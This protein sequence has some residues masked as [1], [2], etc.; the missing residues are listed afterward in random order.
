MQ[1]LEI[2]LYGRNGQKRALSFRPGKVNVITG[3]STTGKSQIIHVIDYCCGSKECRVAPGPLRDKVAWYGLLLATDRGNVFVARQTPPP[4]GKSTVDAYLEEAREGLGSPET[5]E[6]ANTSVVAS[7]RYLRDVVGI[8]EYEFVPTESH[9]T[10]PPLAPTFRHALAFCLQKQTEIANDEHLFHGQGDTYTA[11]AYRDLFPY[12]LG[13]VDTERLSKEQALRQLRAQLRRV[14]TEI[15]EQDDIAGEGLGQ[16]LRL[17]EEARVLGIVTV[18]GNPADVN[19]L[20]EQLREASETWEPGA[21]PL[22]RGDRLSELRT[23]AD[24]ISE[25][26]ERLGYQADAVRS[27]ILNH[28]GRMSANHEQQLR[29]ESIGL[30]EPL[31]TARCSI[32]E[33]G[34]AETG[35]VVGGMWQALSELSET[36]EKAATTRP[37]FSDYLADLDQRR[38]SLAVRLR[39]TEL[40]VEAISMAGEES[41]RLRDVNFRR[42]RAVGRISLWLESVTAQSDTAGLRLEAER[43]KTLVDAAAG[44]L[45]G[46]D[47]AERL[48]SILRRVSGEITRYASRLKLE[49][50]VG[51]DG[52]TN[53][54]TLDIRRLTLIIDE[55]EGP[56]ASNVVGSGKNWL[57]FTVSTHLALHRHFAKQ[58]RPVPNFLVLDQP[59]QVFYPDDRKGDE[60]PQWMIENLPDDDRQEVRNLFD[61]VFDAVEEAGGDMQVI[62]LDHADLPD[63]RFQEAV[64]ER[65][66]GGSAL[67]PLD[68]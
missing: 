7:T 15:Q 48:N 22:V 26:I 64:V 34:L 68:W 47:E 44:A 42:A 28:D 59:T 30:F 20:R 6:S 14:K 37:R 1:I 57:G 65:W 45:S 38:T 61:L 12:F 50:V 66:R 60:D 35:S 11:Q 43:L 5:L 2:V 46:D 53:P 13:A 67:V 4:G 51:P 10:R 29:L 9:H 32:C 56:V 27:H 41:R 62:I 25:E 52:E 58:K 63:T 49:H 33:K 31:D 19:V 8:G 40:A 36:L 23:E 17:L 21:V 3:A 55:P 39:E 54:V 24:V 16:G 18:D